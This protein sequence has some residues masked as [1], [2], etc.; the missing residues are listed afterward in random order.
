MPTLSDA[1][2]L[3]VG[4]STAVWSRSTL[5]RTATS[6][7]MTLVESHVPPSPTSMTPTSTPSSEKCR[8]AATVKSSKR[9][10][11]MPVTASASE[12]RSINAM[13]ASSSIASPF[14]AMRSFDRVQVGARECSH[15]QTSGAQQRAGERG[16]R[17]L[18]VGARD[19]NRRVVV[20]RVGELHQEVP[21]RIE[22]RY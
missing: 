18:A 12:S 17:A 22:A 1:M 10:R 14:T 16:R 20:V 19:V 2:A 5:V 6:E 13:N 11:V 7:S 21:D 8:K 3:T 9:V 15:P 4:P